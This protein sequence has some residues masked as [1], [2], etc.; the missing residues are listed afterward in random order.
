MKSGLRPCAAQF[1]I[2]QPLDK[3]NEAVSLRFEALQ[4]F[5][6]LEPAR[7][8]EQVIDER[9]EDAFGIKV[10]IAIAEDRLE[11]FDRP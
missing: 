8:V 7:V 3:I 1:H 2:F 6:I 5:G 9:Q 4:Q 10:G 11:L